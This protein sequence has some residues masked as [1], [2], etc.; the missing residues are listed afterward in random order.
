MVPGQATDYVGLTNNEGLELPADESRQCRRAA[1][2]GL[3]GG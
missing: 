3:L 2:A 1:I